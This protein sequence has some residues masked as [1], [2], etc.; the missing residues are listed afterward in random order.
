MKVLQQRLAD[1]DLDITVEGDDPLTPDEE[2]IQLRTQITALTEKCN[3]AA[4]H[5][6]AAELFEKHARDTRAELEKKDNDYAP[7][8]NSPAIGEGKSTPRPESAD[9]ALSG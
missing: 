8:N 5:K 4:Q 3:A 2:I 6:R 1:N 7:G 9:R